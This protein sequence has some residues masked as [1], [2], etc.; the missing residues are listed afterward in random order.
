MKKVLVIGAGIAGLSAGIYARRSG[1]DT[2]ILEMHTVPGGN[3]TSWRRGGYLFE[4]GMHWLTGSSQQNPLHRLWTETGALRKDTE[5]YNRDPF[6]TYLGIDREI[7]LYRDPDRL[8]RHLLDISPG[9]IQIIR[10]LTRDIKKFRKMAMPV[11]DVKGVKMKR[12][13]APPLSMMFSMLSVLPRINALGKINCAE[14]AAKFRHPALRRLLESIVGS[15]EFTANSILFTLG[16]LAAG[17]GG[18]PKGGSLVMARNM[19]D[20]FEELGGT[21][22][23][24]TS[25]EKVVLNRDGSVSGVLAGNERLSADA[26]IVTEDTLAAV[27]KLFDPPLHEPWMDEMRRVTKPLLNTFLCFGVETDLSALPENLMFSLEKPL[28]Y[29][30]E[31]FSYL[32]INNYASFKGYAPEGCTAITSALM[33]DSYDYW[34]QARKDGSYYA[35]KESLA[36][37]IMELLG[38][39]FPQMRSKFAVWDVATPLTYERYCGTY[40][41]SWMSVM[42]PGVPQASYPAKSQ[43]AGLYFAGQRMM[44]PGGLPVAVSTG[45]T[46]VQYLCRDTH[47]VFENMV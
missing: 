30:G 7:C 18:Y 26:V 36:S 31:K 29:A 32:G 40:R 10:S 15:K 6:F 22:R 5:I 33:G 19:A 1:F 9:D 37:T 8:E 3:S 47:T 2:E 13:S 17:D 4:G 21:I 39:Q 28:L 44:S 42:Q 41:G 16:T 23:Y 11:M 35:K 46:A 25:V 20:R 34:K 12:K 24:G 27:D 43:I 38:K 45:R 14:Y